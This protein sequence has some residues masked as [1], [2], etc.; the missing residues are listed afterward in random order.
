MT[1]ESGAVGGD[2]SFHKQLT[3]DQIKQQIIQ[4]IFEYMNAPE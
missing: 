3:K 2:Q 1:G 4:L